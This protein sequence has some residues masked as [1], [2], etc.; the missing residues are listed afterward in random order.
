[1]QWNDKFCWGDFLLGVGNLTRSDFDCSENCYLVGEMNLWWEGN[2]V[3]A[4]ES[5]GA[6]FSWWEGMSKF[7]ASGWRGLPPLP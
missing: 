2:L 7:S 1:M 3:G 5:T 6:Y 4:G